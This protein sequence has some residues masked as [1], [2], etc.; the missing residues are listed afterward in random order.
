L[1]DLI[2]GIVLHAFDDKSPFGTECLNR[3]A[4]RK[5]IYQL[6]LDSKASHKLVEQKTAPTL[7]QKPEPTGDAGTR[8]KP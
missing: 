6:D 1:G 4:D 7:A 3:I 8:R 2:E 5:Q